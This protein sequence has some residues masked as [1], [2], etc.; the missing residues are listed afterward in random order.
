MGKETMSDEHVNRSQILL[1]Q[2]EGG[3]QRIEVRLEYGSVWLSQALLAELFQTTIANIN[4]HIKNIYKDNELSE[5]A[6][7]KDYLIVRQEGGK[8]VNRTVKYYNLE[9]ILAIGYRVRFIE[10]S[11]FV[12]G[13][14]N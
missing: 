14:Q 11:N 12:N 10:V 3:Q 9:M 2:T 4:L 8:Q 7:I 6:T 13:L 1:Y 5:K